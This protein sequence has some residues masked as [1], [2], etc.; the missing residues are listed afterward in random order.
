MYNFKTVKKQPSGKAVDGIIR[1]ARQPR[2]TETGG[3]FRRVK[4]YRPE[5]APPRARKTPIGDFRQPTA[6]SITDRARPL[7]V[8]GSTVAL[9]Q[10]WDDRTM[11]DDKEKPNKKAGKR[12]LWPFGKGKDKTKKKPRT[13]KQKIRRG[14]LIFLLLGILAGAFMFGKT[15]WNA[16]KV[17][18]G[19]GGSPALQQDC[20]DLSQLKVEGD[21][22]VNVMILGKGG[23]SHEAPDL[24]DTIIIASIDPIHKEA[25]LVSIPR[26]LYVQADGGYGY[27]KI[28]AVYAN[29]KSASFAQ[30]NRSN[31]AKKRAEQAGLTAIEKTLE[32]KLG[33]PIH[34]YGMIDFEG[35]RRAVD[36]V[37]GVTI[38]VKEPLIDPSV[39]WENNW[40]ATIAT[41]GVQKFDG[42]KALL[43]ARSRQ[44]SPRG[45]FDRSQR[46]R[47]VIVALKDKIFTAGTYGNPVKV[48]QLI[49]T[50]GSR[51]STNFSI[52]EIMKLYGIGKDMPSANIKSIGLS[53]P[54]NDYLTT[55][56][57]NG[58]S[59]VVPKAGLDNYDAIRKYIR[60]VLVDPRIRQE[61]AQVVVLNGTPTAGLAAK[62]AAVLKSFGYNIGEVKDAPT[63]DYQKTVIVDLRSGNKKYTKH[64]LER[65]FGVSVTDKLPSGIVAPETADF[66]IILGQNETS[67]Q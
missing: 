26:D 67:A 17:L 62:K 42:K 48:S 56:T 11:N 45:D 4:S 32:N 43:Y 47:E 31:A 24:T 34:Y 9:E 59:V 51:V 10:P 27:T 41:K 58:Q 23:G 15:Y 18:S 20:E 16:R 33:I 65:R 7:S 25:A 53:D 57:Y 60:K 52:D 37:G 30:S 1:P 46:Q 36:T 2:T 19:G 54:P 44:S 49:D 38:D 21:C 3:Q 12:R 5:P 39:A 66:V 13:K 61:N 22:R 14:L 63:K 55:D 40:N 28:N 35:F 6:R 8:S 29:A 64:Y 50:F